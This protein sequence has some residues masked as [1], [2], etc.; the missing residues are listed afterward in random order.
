MLMIDAQVDLQEAQQQVVQ[1]R[2]LVHAVD[3]AQVEQHTR[4]AATAAR[5]ALAAAA[6]AFAELRY[7]RA[8]LLVALLVILVAIGALWLEIRQLDARRR[9][10]ARRKA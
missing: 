5:K 4:A 9:I 2:T 10:E 7:R 1:A 3:P 6:R 8:G